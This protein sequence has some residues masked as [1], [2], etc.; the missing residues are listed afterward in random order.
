L[1]VTDD[2]GVENSSVVTEKAILIS[3]PPKPKIDLSAAACAGEEVRLAVSDSGLIA[4]KPVEAG[5]QAAG[6][7]NGAFA[8]TRR[9]DRPG[10]YDVTILTDDGHGLG[11]SRKPETRMLHI[12]RPPV[13]LAGAQQMVCPGQAVS[14]D[15][16][17]SYDSDGRIT[18][19]Q[20]DFGDGGSAEGAMASHPFD[21]PGTY[22]VKLRVTDDT[23]SSC[24]STTSTTRVIVNA[25]P[26]AD[27]G[28][29]REAFAGGAADAALLDGSRSHDPDGQA[30]THVWQIGDGTVESGERV[31]HM[32]RE[33][34]DIPVKLT[35][36]DT[37]GLSCG[38][39]SES[40]VV[41][42]RSRS[43]P[44]NN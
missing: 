7:E 15:G 19:Y 26:V 23:D 2:A 18:H 42:V 11:N 6:Q 39:A 37:S 25:P 21:R 29:L 14:F 20:W 28:P 40:F 30:L 44:V 17:H 31:R 36:T 27:A 8:F 34:G 43:P 22:D 3:T 38:Q 4:A 13:S 41:K 16:S 24:A 12:N 32:F 5:W 10:R 9:F 33:V 35:V 1:K